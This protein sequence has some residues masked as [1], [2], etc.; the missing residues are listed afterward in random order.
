[1]VVGDSGA[2]F[3][4]PLLEAA[5]PDVE[6][7]QRGVVGC[8]IANAGGGSWSEGYGFLA[9]PEGCDE[10]PRR[11]SA[12]AAE[13]RPDD[14]LIVLSWPGI[15]DRDLDGARRHPCDPVFDAY[16]EERLELA[17][18][19]AGAGGGAVT[20]VTVPYPVADAGADGLAVERVDCLNRSVR[21]AASRSGATVLDLAGWLCPTTRCRREIDGHE[22][23]P[24]GLHFDGEGGTL[25]AAWIMDG[26]ATPP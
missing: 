2:Y 25:V 26:L 15:G 7:L 24:D 12:D 19:S 18:A 5:A 20:L 23:R 22:L 6:V 14:V 4:G 11:W 17:V 1:M 13:F 3:I 9:D 10:W 8:G 16:Y 21:T